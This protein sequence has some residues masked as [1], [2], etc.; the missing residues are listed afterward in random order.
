MKFWSWALYWAISIWSPLCLIHGLLYIPLLIKIESITSFF[1]PFHDDKKSWPTFSL[2]LAELK[3]LKEKNISTLP[4]RRER[5]KLCKIAR[6]PLYL[7]SVILP[8]I[9]H[10]V[11]H[12]S[13]SPG[14]CHLTWR[15]SSYLASVILPGICYLTWHLSS[16]PGTCHLTW[17]LSSFPGICLLFQASVFL[18]GICYLTWHLSSFPGI[19]L[20]T[21]HLS[22]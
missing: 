8:D 9:C 13:S 16:S 2:R 21:W 6:V 17:R 19:C 20:V 1:I 4:C 15:L 10:L 12:L 22:S 11:W 7:L 5:V 18:P 3:P 14:T